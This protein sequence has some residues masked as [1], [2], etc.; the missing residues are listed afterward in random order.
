MVFLIGIPF[1]LSV[2]ICMQLTPKCFLFVIVL[3]YVRT[4]YFPIHQPLFS[5]YAFDFL[6]M[7][8]QNTLYYYLF[9]LIN[10]ASALYNHTKPVIIK[11][12]CGAPIMITE[13]VLSRE[14]PIIAHSSSP[15]PQF[16][17]TPLLQRSP[18]PNTIDP[19]HLTQLRA[20]F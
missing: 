17:C 15:H 13:T 20:R 9:I 10:K 8:Q 6:A 18:V 2:T 4:M 12:P 11:S 14:I 19:V 5:Y 16:H 3:I 1:V 7:Y